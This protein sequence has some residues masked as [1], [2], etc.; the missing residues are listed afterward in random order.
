M[1]DGTACVFVRFVTFLPHS[2]LS[3]SKD[4]FNV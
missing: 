2:T 1:S 4:P 3:V